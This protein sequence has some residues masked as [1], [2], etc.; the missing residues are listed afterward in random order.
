M[1]INSLHCSRRGGLGGRGVDVSPVQVLAPDP[2]QATGTFAGVSLFHHLQN[3]QQHRCFMGER[4]SRSEKAP[5]TGPLCQSHSSCWEGAAVTMVVLHQHVQRPRVHTPPSPGPQAE[6]LVW[7]GRAGVI[8]TNRPPLC[9]PQL[10]FT[11]DKPRLCFRVSITVTP[12]G[13]GQG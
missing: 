1:V 8:Q 3:G 9:R 6:E 13:R 11:G 12:G 7:E 10:P 4:M 2:P 5:H